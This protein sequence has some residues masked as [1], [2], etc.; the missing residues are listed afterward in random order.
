M[1]SGTMRYS[2]YCCH[3]GGGSH[4]AVAPG[5][6]RSGA[7]AIESPR[8]RVAACP[9]C[10]V[11]FVIVVTSRGGFPSVSREILSPIRDGRRLRTYPKTF[12]CD[13]PSKSRPGGVLV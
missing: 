13:E 6:A 2:S 4:D 8:S 3:G 9:T 1:R 7:P 10:L 12:T 11:R 5:L